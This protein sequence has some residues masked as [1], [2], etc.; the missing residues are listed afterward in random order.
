MALHYLFNKKDPLHRYMVKVLAWTLS[1]LH[2]FLVTA[3]CHWSH[4]RAGRKKQQT[5]GQYLGF[6]QFYL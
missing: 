3:F 6:L 4:G 2:S 1:F 5:W